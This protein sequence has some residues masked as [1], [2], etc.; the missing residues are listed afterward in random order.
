MKFA[1][2]QTQYT[3][4]KAVVHGDEVMCAVVKTRDDFGID[5][6]KPKRLTEKNAHV[7]YEP[8]LLL[9]NKDGMA[10]YLLNGEKKYLSIDE[11]KKMEK[12]KRKV[13]KL[14]KKRRLR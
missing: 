7:K 1:T 8:R 2:M 12:A 6:K 10:Y 3:R 5:S 4:G 14:I 9:L 13:Q 11:M